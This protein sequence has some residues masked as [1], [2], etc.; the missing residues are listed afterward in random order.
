MGNNAAKA[1]NRVLREIDAEFE[2]TN[3]P[4]SGPVTDY[5]ASYFARVKN[6]DELFR[7]GKDLSENLKKGIKNVA[8]TSP[9]L[10]NSQQKT[11]LGVCCFFDRV[12]H[13]KIAIVSDQLKSGVFQDL[14]TNSKTMNH[15]LDMTGYNMKYISY[16]HH[17]DFYDY[18]NLL[19]FYET[20]LYNETFDKELA[21]LFSMY[22]LVLWDVP[23]LS[24]MKLS[25]HFHYRLSSFYQSMTLIV[26][27]HSS[28]KQIEE[29][30]DYF[31]TF[32][33]NL[34]KVLFDT[35]FDEQAPKKKKFLGIF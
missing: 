21:K 20:H 23:E 2:N 27:P 7:F 6:N 25:P 29:L 12:E 28:I 3:S 4:S 13:L 22:D 8:F 31:S 24:K 11:I 14:V 5:L 17:F 16:F 19:N 10:K 35:S 1:I 33:M 15:H 18:E 30:R 34:S 9:G 26:S 32:R